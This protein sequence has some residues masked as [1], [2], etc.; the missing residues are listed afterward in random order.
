LDFGFWILDFGF[1][2]GD[3]ELAVGAGF[4]R[5]DRE[6]TG[7]LGILDWGFSILDWLWGRVSHALTE[8]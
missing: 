8:K 1:W 2:I 5:P 3:W 7:R 6:I 4:P